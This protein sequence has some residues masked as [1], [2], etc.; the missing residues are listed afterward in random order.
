MP[1]KNEVDDLKRCR[2]RRA[3]QMVVMV[4]CLWE[5]MKVAVP[6]LSLVHEEY[7][8]IYRAA[9]GKTKLRNVHKNSVGTMSFSFVGQFQRN[10]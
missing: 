3:V 7:P 6:G 5:I 1:R 9:T 8:F 10:F 2:S 4:W